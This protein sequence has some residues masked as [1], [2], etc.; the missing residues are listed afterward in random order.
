MNTHRHTYTDRHSL[1]APSPHPH[2]LLGISLTLP[3]TITM[4][5]LYVRQV[6]TNTDENN[7]SIIAVLIFG[8]AH[9]A[10]NHRITDQSA[11][12]AGENMPQ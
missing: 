7:I 5:T 6:N 1:L 12:Q 11:A 9:S 3:T 4:T 10:P 8:Y 2:N